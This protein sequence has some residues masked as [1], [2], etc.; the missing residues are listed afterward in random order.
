MSA[1]RLPLD[2]AER[3]S[4]ATLRPAHPDNDAHLAGFASG[5][6]GAS[7]H[8]NPHAGP[9]FDLHR[10]RAWNAGWLEARQSSP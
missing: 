6:A 1:P 5:M 7:Q 3:V 2:G 10:R 9:R 4:R 8:D